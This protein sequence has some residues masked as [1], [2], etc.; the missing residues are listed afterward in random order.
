MKKSLL[1]QALLISKRELKNHTENY[2]HWSFIVKNNQIIEWATNHCGKPP[3][4]LG[5]NRRLDEGFSAKTHSELAAYKRAKGIMSGSFEII[6]IRLNKSGELKN[7][8]PCS[9]CFQFLS[10]IGCTKGYFSTENNFQ[11]IKF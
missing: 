4:N 5:Y 6:N 2:L 9:C 3:I 8:K 10:E 11:K 1:F 7:S